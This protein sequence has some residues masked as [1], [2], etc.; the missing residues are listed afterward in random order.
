MDSEQYSDIKF[1]KNHPCGK[2]GNFWSIRTT[3]M[4]QIWKLNRIGCSTVIWCWKRKLSPGGQN[5]NFWSVRATW[6]VPTWKLGKST[7]SAI[8]WHKKSPWWLKWQLLI[9]NSYRD[10]LNMK[11]ELNWMLSSISGVKL[12][13]PPG[14]Q[15]IT[16]FQKQFC[17]KF[18]FDNKNVNPQS[19]TP[20]M[21]L[22]IWVC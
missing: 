22:S 14:G 12:N 7:C 19:G 8:I 16:N 2:N 4:V 11:I 15:K 6:M 13:C 21:Y 9:H 5:G 1:K 3:E 10:G 17:G 20:I 18:L